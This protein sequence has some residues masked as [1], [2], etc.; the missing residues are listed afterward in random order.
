MKLEYAVSA[1][2]KAIEA[3]N[4]HGVRIV[5]VVVD[6]GG[7]T[8]V[9]QRM[10]GCSYVNTDVAVRKATLASA[11]GASTQQIGT[12]VGKD[13]IAA[14]VLHAD[15]RLCMLP[16]G[17]PLMDAGTCVGAL[18]IAG[19]HYMQDQAIADFAVAQ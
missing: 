16:G 10:E 1:V 15:N 13:P 5:A 8:V 3:A 2:Q 12:M 4:S 19:A 14:P 9:T 17:V 11:F 18:G 6:T 7:H